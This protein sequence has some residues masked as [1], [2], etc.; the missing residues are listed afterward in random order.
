MAGRY[1]PAVPLFVVERKFAE[2]IDT[3]SSDDVKL[4]AENNADEGV[5]WLESFLTA[6]RRHSYCLYEAPSVDAILAAS[7][8]NNL[9]VEAIVE[10]GDAPPEV[11]ARLGDRAGVQPGR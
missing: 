4:L 10:L 1:D 7:K 2:Q 8:R 11:H 5:T 6:D 9:P 3:L